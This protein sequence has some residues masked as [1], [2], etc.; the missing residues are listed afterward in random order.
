MRRQ[1]GPASHAPPPHVGSPG[2]H[3]LSGSSPDVTRQQ[4]ED[5]HQ[6]VGLSGLAEAV[7]D[8]DALDAMLGFVASSAQSGGFEAVIAAEGMRVTVGQQG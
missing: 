7:R 4:A 6:L 2:P 3:G 1:G 8:T 5:V